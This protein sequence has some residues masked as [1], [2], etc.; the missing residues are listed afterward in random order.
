MRRPSFPVATTRSAGGFT[1]LELL[2][3]MTVIAILASVAIPSYQQ[4][5]MRSRRADARVAMNAVASRLERCFTQ[6]GAY[7]ADECAIESPA[8]SPE[9]F[10]EVSVVRDAAAYA[11]TAEPQ[12]A[13]ADDTACGTLSVTSTGLRAATGET[14]DRCW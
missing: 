12:G 2:V 7:D 9:G 10:Y 14:P 4:S 3:V 11:L 8:D 5:V 6:F 13:Q 1:L